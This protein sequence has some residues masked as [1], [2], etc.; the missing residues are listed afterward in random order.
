MTDTAAVEAYLHLH[1]PISREMGLRVVSIDERG[2]RLA[3]PLAPN[4]NHQSTA[5]GGS[6]SSVV[7]LA[8]WTL[9]HVGLRERDVRA[10]VVIQKSRVEYLH[11]IEGDFEAV[12]PMPAARE[13]ERFVAGVERRGRGRIRLPAEV[14]FD[15]SVCATFE[16][17][18]VA[19]SEA[20]SG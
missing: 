1:I 19:I 14:L 18:Y 4:T 12:C 5:F 16:G 8:A 10:T 15:G 11:P 17:S 13:W 6:I 7:I 3:A 20:S 9:A 2:V